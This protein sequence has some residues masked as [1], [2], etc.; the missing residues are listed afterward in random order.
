[1]DSTFDSIFEF[2]VLH[3]VENWSAG[4]HEAGRLLRPGGV[5]YAQET[6]EGFICHPIW[7]R[8]MEHPQEKRFQKE[9]FIAEAKRAGFRILGTQNWGNQFLWLAAEREERA[10]SH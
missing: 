10:S 3:H 7:R 2:N 9:D 8:C 6:L 5:F 4:I 1:M